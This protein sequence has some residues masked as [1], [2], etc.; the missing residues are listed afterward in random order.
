MRTLDTHS[1]PQPNFG[2]CFAGDGVSEKQLNR[3]F[4][5]PDGQVAVIIDDEFVSLNMMNPGPLVF[6]F[7]FAERLNFAL[8]L[9]VL[10]GIHM[11]RKA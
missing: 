8:G 1:P 7:F 10:P 3:T 11:A 6:H 4:E 9:Q 2:F 5:G